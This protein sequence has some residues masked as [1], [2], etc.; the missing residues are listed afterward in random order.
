MTWKTSLITLFALGCAAGPADPVD[1]EAVG[2]DTAETIDDG[3]AD[4]TE[5]RVR[6]ANLTV[7][8]DKAIVLRP[9]SDGTLTAVI[10]GRASRN[11]DRA[12][13]FVPDDPFGEAEL[14]GPRSF[15]VTLDVG[16]ELDSMLSGLPLLIGLGVASDPATSYTVKL[17]VAAA[18]SR[19]EGASQ[20]H[21]GTLVRP[22]FIG[23]AEG[24]GDPLRYRIDVHATG[25]SLELTNAGAP[26]IVSD[27]DGGFDA[28]LSY[29]DLEAALR[30][31]TKVGFL[32]GTRLKKASV[33]VRATTV[34][35]TVLDPYDVWPG[36]RCDLDAYTCS[37]DNDGYDLASCGSYRVVQR[38]QVTDVCEVMD[39]APL[40][41]RPL[42]LS[43]AWSAEADAYRQGCSGGGSW[44]SLGTI[45]AF[46]L[47]ACLASTP[48]LRQVVEH[49]ARIT[50]TQDFAAGPYAGGTVLTRTGL[51]STPLFGDAYSAGS[52]LFQAIDAFMGA[53]ELRTWTVT[54]E[55]SCQNCHDFRSRTFLWWPSA[56]RLVVIDSG[57]GYDS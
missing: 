46:T 42:D 55:L 19:F 29:G 36:P 28:L 20:I 2:P 56:A 31:P 21:L 48:T 24:D 35:M 38:C 4:A 8:I 22:V 13:S 12:F 16:H 9:R 6:V 53:G 1:G 40:E 11:L 51:A 10:R 3:K 34:A 30:S 45:Q 39:V 44:C 57:H 18:L 47:P 33:G 37:R 52:G 50:D 54:E 41:L 27:P 17:D 32:A 49:A 43:F 15:E 25:S 7:W 5:L 14:L 23:D 26:T